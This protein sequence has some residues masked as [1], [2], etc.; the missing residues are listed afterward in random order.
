ME[1]PT[2][3][4]NNPYQAPSSNNPYTFHFVQYFP[5][6]INQL[7]FQNATTDAHQQRGEEGRKEATHNHT[8]WGSNPGY[9]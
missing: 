6:Y 2:P 1:V 5:H 4:T 8:Q 7:S 9:D 3:T